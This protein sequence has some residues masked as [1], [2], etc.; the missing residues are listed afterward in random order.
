M[1]PQNVVHNN[2][3]IEKITHDLFQ[4]IV[5]KAQKILAEVEEQ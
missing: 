5:K 4:V 2:S 1:V 3:E